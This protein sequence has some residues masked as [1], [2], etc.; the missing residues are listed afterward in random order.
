M[1]QSAFGNVTSQSYGGEFGYALWRDTQVFV[2][3]GIIRNVA[4]PSLSGGAQTI[5]GALTQLQS[6]P[7][8][9]SVKQPVTF[10]AAGVRYPWRVTD[11]LIRAGVALGFAF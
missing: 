6:E 2:E 7:V 5:A 9:Y 3:G 10:F 1:A 8:A 11:L 4:T